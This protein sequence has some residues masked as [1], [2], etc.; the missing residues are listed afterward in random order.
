MRVHSCG[1]AGI[2]NVSRPFAMSCAAAA[3]PASAPRKTMKFVT[4]FGLCAVRIARQASGMYGVLGRRNA[5]TSVRGR[6][7]ARRGTSDD[8]RDIRDSLGA[9]SQHKRQEEVTLLDLL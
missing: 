8:C 2:L 7:M 6:A 1:G 4:G 9:M 3:W 5:A